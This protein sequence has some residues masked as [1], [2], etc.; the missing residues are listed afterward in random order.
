M[1]TGWYN[2]GNIKNRTIFHQ[3]NNSEDS[4]KNYSIEGGKDVSDKVDNSKITF[5]LCVIKLIKT[6]FFDPISDLYKELK[7]EFN[8]S[9]LMHIS[10]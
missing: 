2:R 8:V 4:K 6:D 5:H 3:N 7:K 1:V 9:K 10:L